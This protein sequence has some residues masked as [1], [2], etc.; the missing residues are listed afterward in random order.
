V[1][2]RLVQQ[3]LRGSDI[4]VVLL[5]D[6]DHVAVGEELFRHRLLAGAEA[7]SRPVRAM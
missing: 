7:T 4:G 5:L 2:E 1:L 3:L 6:P